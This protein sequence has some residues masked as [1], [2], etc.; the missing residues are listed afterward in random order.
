[1]CVTITQIQ[2]ISILPLNVIIPPHLLQNIKYHSL[3]NLIIAYYPYKSNIIL[4]N[5]FIFI[6]LKD[7]II[8][9]IKMLNLKAIGG[10][11]KKYRKQKGF[12]QAQLAE[13]IDISTIHM[14]HL[15]TGSV[16]MSL[17]CMI[18]VCNALEVSPDDLLIGEFELNNNATIKQL[19]E[20]TKNLSSDEN[21]LLIDFA[22]LLKKNKPNRN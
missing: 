7:N 5:L 20:I 21:K 4:K 8:L 1:M 9:V 13:I 11:I 10:R 16:A 14:S 22:I 3:T 2:D 15:E 18:K 19:A 17:E 6:L 12:T